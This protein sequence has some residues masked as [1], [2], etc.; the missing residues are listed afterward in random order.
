MELYFLMQEGPQYSSVSDLAIIEALQPPQANTT[1]LTLHTVQ[2]QIENV[3]C[4][5]AIFGIAVDQEVGDY[6]YKIM[7]HLAY[8]KCSYPTGSLTKFWIQDKT[9]E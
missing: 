6:V 1:P 8:V 3:A 2:A 7:G 4:Q 5:L 9:V